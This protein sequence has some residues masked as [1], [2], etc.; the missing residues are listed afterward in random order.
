VQPGHVQ[1]EVHVMV[2]WPW[3]WQRTVLVLPGEH[4]VESSATQAVV[5]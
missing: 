2:F 4:L 1:L 3:S 5:A